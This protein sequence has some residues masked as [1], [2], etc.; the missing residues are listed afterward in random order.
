MAA[1]LP[2]QTYSFD[3]RGFGIGFKEL[4]KICITLTKVASIPINDEKPTLINM[5]DNLS[6][7][8]QLLVYDTIKELDLFT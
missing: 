8:G 7:S 2:S 6:E 4:T 5:H 3:R 1:P